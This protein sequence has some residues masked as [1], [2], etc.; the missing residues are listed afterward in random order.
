MLESPAWSVLSLSARRFLDR[1]AIELAHHG[2]N[3]IDKLPLTY[4]QLERHGMDR[5]AIA[6]AIREAAALGFVAIT[7]SGCGGNAEFRRPTLYRITFLLG[8][9]G[10]PEPT[11]DWRKFKTVEEARVA[12]QMARDQKQLQYKK[13]G[14]PVGGS[15]TD[16][17]QKTGVGSSRL[18]VGVPHTENGKSPVGVSPTTT[19]PEKPPPRSRF[20]GRGRR[21]AT[22]LP[23]TA[24]TAVPP[25]ATALEAAGEEGSGK[26]VMDIPR[27]AD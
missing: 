24:P 13:R 16:Q 11:H 12:A 1:L 26:L 2:G 15:T 8:R 27:G 4:E 9:A 25:D 22:V 23:L 14:V 3:D 7:Q 10:C 6:P 20:R 18:P 5:H 19:S 21:G 17:K